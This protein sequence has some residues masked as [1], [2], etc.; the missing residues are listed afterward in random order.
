MECGW[1]R[2]RD[3]FKCVQEILLI[4]LHIQLTVAQ[5]P[6]AHKWVELKGPPLS[7]YLQLAHYQV[8]THHTP[9]AQINKKHQILQLRTL[10][11]V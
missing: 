4:F 9:I 5:T 1:V 10:Q 6:N 2:E 11:R 7:T 3:V 8:Y